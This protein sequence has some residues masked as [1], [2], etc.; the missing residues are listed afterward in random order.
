MILS[1]SLWAALDGVGF[2]AIRMLLSVLWQSSI[3]LAAV[4]ILSFA[5]RRRRAAVRRTL[6]VLALVAAP[7]LPLI[8]W[9][10]ANTG[11]PSAEI[12]VMPAY[13]PLTPP[14]V[15]VVEPLTVPMPTAPMVE[16]V[17]EAPP[18]PAPEPPEL[19][20]EISSEPQEESAKVY[21]WALGLLGYA[22]GGL[23]FLTLI[24]LGRLR[25]AHW[26]R[27]G[28]L[29]TDQRVLTAF[30][31][32]ARRLGLRR[33]FT[34]VKSDDIHAPVAIR[35]FH[36]LVLLPKGFAGPET[37]DEELQAV[38]IHELAHIKR[39]DPLILT[40]VSLT[41]AV[42]FFHPL[43][44]LAARRVSGLSE[45]CADDA[46]LEA[47]HAP[48][49]YAQMLARLA[50]ELPRRAL[51]AELA[52]GLLFS[53]SAFL[54]RV[55]AILSDNRERIKKLS[56]LALLATV[57]ALLLSLGI[58]VAL[59]L[60]EKAE[61]LAYAADDKNAL[62][63]VG[64][65]VDGGDEVLDLEGKPT[66]HRLYTGRMAHWREGGRLLDLLFRMPDDMKTVQLLGFEM[67]TSQEGRPLGGGMDPAF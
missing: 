11:T 52:A 61:D 53:R 31:A 13:V 36:P 30:R 39:H 16:P 58:A 25:L 43:V 50:E 1:E 54:H 17:A 44:W 4:G 65:C 57:A 6:W 2:R 41:R 12:A 45:Q 63:L 49:P 29:L 46:V 15:P 48:I 27:R 33:D 18:M 47:T 7:L 19:P 40:L 10:L 66:G 60:G 22:A 9:G 14:V 21:P 59:P 24:V 8:G 20:G 37:T 62:K 56:R 34:I 42:L 51:G 32:A 35:V 67:R 38:A 26:A 5:L 55:E 28:R 3:L 23:F 64:V